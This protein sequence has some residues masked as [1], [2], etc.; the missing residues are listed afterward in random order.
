M[1]QRNPRL[2]DKLY[3]GG[4]EGEL[5]QRL[6]ETPAQPTAPSIR[7]K[8]VSDGLFSIGQDH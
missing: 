8:L 7:Y 4:L 5:L 6:P 3:T 2:R 1:I